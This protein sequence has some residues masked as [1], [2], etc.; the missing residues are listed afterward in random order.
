MSDKSYEA[1]L[2]SNGAEA[3]RLAVPQGALAG[4][5]GPGG[6]PATSSCTLEAGYQFQLR[7]LQCVRN[8][9]S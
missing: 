1:K 4:Q 3:D 2:K 7:P 6:R 5:A 8:P 9:T